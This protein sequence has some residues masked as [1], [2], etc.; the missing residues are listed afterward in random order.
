MTEHKL[1][2]LINEYKFKHEIFRLD[3]TRITTLA[4]SCFDIILQDLATEQLGKE[5]G[6]KMKIKNP[7]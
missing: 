6:K 1:V 7:N 3:W 5:K 2:H 4:Q